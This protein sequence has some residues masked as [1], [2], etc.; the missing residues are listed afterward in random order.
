MPDYSVN[1]LYSGLRKVSFLTDTA[2]SFT[3]PCLVNDTILI[4]C[5]SVGWVKGLSTTSQKVIVAVK[6]RRAGLFD[7]CKLQGD[8]SVGKC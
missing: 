7:S 6:D 3:G 2:S 8:D 1:N 4:Y 5:N